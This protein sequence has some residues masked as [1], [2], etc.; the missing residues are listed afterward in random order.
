MSAPTSRT[1]NGGSPLL[2]GKN[3]S[4]VTLGKYN[5]LYIKLSTRIGNGGSPCGRTRF[6]PTIKQLISYKQKRSGNNVLH[7]A[8]CLPDLNF[9][10]S[11]F[12]FQFKNNARVIMFELLQ[13]VFTNGVQRH[14]AGGSPILNCTNGNDVTLG[15]IMFFNIKLSTR[16]GNGSI[17]C[18]CKLLVEKRFL[19]YNIIK[20]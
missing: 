3:Y 11:I 18:N 14:A 12:N 7:F 6:F 13:T 9:P 17:P 19:H 1:G 4:N 16:T 10:F 8:N 5:C 20:R 15:H 2:G